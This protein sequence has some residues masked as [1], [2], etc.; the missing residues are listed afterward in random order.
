VYDSS[1]GRLV[2]KDPASGF[3]F[4]PLTENRYVYVLNRPLVFED[5]SGLAPDAASSDAS[6]FASAQNLSGSP[7]SAEI[8]ASALSNFLTPQQIGP[9]VSG[10][11]VGLGFL[12]H[13]PTLIVS[14]P[15]AGAY[16]TAIAVGFQTGRI[17]GS[18]PIVRQNVSNILFSG[19]NTVF[20]PKRIEQWSSEPGL[21]TWLGNV[22]NSLAI[23]QPQ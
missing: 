18:V 6:P 8:V 13:S 19:L 9:A 20:G 17:I 7:S 1:V 4:G 3:I 11:S 16:A 14:A 22:G 21:F 2:T 12:V 10:A 15:I 5:P 23:Q